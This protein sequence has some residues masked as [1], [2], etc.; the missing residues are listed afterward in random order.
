MT[1]EE[2]SKM[3]VIELLDNGGECI[4][5]RTRKN[6]TEAVL[7]RL[8]HNSVTPY[9]TWIRLHSDPNG[10]SLGHYFKADEADEA[11]SDFNKR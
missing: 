2:L 8:R 4:G 6:G 11:W 5:R 7:A 10:T 3:P 9:A 1:Q